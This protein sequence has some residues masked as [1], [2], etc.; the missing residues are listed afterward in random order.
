MGQ[1]SELER[2]IK[3]KTVWGGKRGASQKSGGAMAH[4]APPPLESPLSICPAGASILTSQ[5][6]HA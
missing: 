6:G 2:E 3:Q 4:P 1:S 5:C